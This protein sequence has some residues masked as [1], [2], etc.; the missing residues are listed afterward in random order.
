MVFPGQGSQYVGM[1]KKLA[2]Q[3]PLAKEVF[4]EVDDALGAPL[5]K[6]MC[7]GPEEQLILTKNAQPALMANSVAVVRVIEAET[8]KK[9]SDLVDYVAG[10]SLGE[11]S[12]LAAVNSISLND[13]AKLLRLRG[14]SMQAAV[15]IGDGAMAALLGAGMDAVTNIINEASKIGICEIAN[16]NAPGQIVISG[17]A[18]AVNKAIKISSDFGVRKAMS[19][20]VSAPFH[21][22]MMKPAAEVMAVALKKTNI[23][24]PDVPLVANVSAFVGNGDPSEIRNSLVEQVTSLVRWRETILWLSKQ[25][26]SSVIEIGAGKILSGLNKRIDKHL[27]SVSIAELEEIGNFLTKVEAGE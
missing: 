16:D 8:Q 23:T 11:Y 26:I 15:P 20:P 9:I 7:E 2:E 17:E 1:G 24:S 19:L 13:A 25:D 27:T 22:S 4:Q 21:C 5:F 12:A 14:E 3:H 6:L 10:H 18:K